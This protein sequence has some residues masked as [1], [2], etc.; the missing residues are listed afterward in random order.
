MLYLSSC[1]IIHATYNGSTVITI[2]GDVK[3]DFTYL[4]H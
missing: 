4:L 2:K 3:N 1:Q